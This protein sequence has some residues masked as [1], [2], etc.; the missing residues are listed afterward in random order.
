MGRPTVQWIEKS[1]LPRGVQKM[2]Q[3]FETAF[4]LHD[5]GYQVTYYRED[6][7]F[8]QVQG[9]CDVYRLARMALHSPDIR[10]ELEASAVQYWTLRMF[11]SSWQIEH[12]VNRSLPQ[13]TQPLP[14]DDLATRG[15]FVQVHDN[16]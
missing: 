9:I 8:V 15:Q 1:A 5:R 3:R 6:T 10:L 16:A 11:C 2:L 12:E 14:P 7:V 13:I 4:G